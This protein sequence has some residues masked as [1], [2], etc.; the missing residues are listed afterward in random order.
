MIELHKI[1]W[2]GGIIGL[3]FLFLSIVKW[4]MLTIYWSKLMFGVG[5]GFVILS[6]AY[7]H[8]CLK[9]KDKTDNH[10]EKRI[11]ESEFN[12]NTIAEHLGIK[13]EK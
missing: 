3:L 2:I 5:I 7:I 11:T 6:L 13:L 9:M 10:N 1:T 12:I 8:E 4:F